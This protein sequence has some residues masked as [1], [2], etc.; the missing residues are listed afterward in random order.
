MWNGFK[1]DAL[2]QGCACPILLEPISNALT[3]QAVTLQPHGPHD[4]YGLSEAVYPQ[5]RSGTADMKVMAVGD[6]LSLTLS[7]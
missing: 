7:G 2:T 6:D 4:T 1:A 5:D 3:K